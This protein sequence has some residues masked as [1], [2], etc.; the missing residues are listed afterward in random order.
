MR[1]AIRLID[2]LV[3]KSEGVYEFSDDPECILRFQHKRATHSVTI[4]KDR[5][6]KGEPVLE[7]HAWNERMPRLLK[8]GATLEWALQLRRRVIHSFKGVA[9][10]MLQDHQ[11]SR[12]RAVCGT[13]A[14]FSFSAHTGGTRLMQHLGFAV[15][16]YHRPLGKFGEFWENFFSWWLMW[17]YNDA[18]LHSREFWR[19]QRTEI[20]MTAD[21]FIRR[22]GG[23]LDITIEA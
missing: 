8:E 15:L 3:R 13:S 19:L 12:V 20:W 21:E 9:K 17:T 23:A 18:S 5:I 7:V 4:G 1:A 14:L 10:V 6:L 16:P 22:Y 2:T 11:Y